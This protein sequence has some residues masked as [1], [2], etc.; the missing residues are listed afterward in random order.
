MRNNTFIEADCGFGNIR[1]L[2]SYLSHFIQFTQGR[3]IAGHSLFGAAYLCF[4][5][6]KVREHGK[7]SLTK[8]MTEL[9]KVGELRRAY[10][11]QMSTRESS[12]GPLIR[13]T[14]G[15]KVSTLPEK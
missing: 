11:R 3:S 7:V 6:I 5:V 10:Q 9:L 1:F 13:D 4:L 15:E 12:K 14:P 8:I 2:P